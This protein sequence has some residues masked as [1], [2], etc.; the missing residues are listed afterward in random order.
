MKLKCFLTFL[1]IICTACF[2]SFVAFAAPVSANKA[3]DFINQTGYRLIEALGNPNLEEKYA[4]LDDMF[5]KNVD[6]PY[7]ARFV[8]GKY[9]KQMTEEQKQTYIALFP[10]YVIGVYKSYPL[11]FG[12]EGLNFEILSTIPSGNYTDV[13]C[14]IDLPES[15][16]TEKVPNIDVSFKLEEVQHQ[17]KIID[18]KIGESSLLVSYRKRFYEMIMEADEDMSWFLEDFAALTESAERNAEDKLLAQ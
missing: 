1:T 6:I 16:K 15:L 8:M 11:N 18:L 3:K 4:V 7:L 17:P 13:F 9:W 5:Q 12:T 14:R 2:L 10:R